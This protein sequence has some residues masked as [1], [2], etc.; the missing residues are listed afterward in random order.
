MPTAWMLGEKMLTAG[1]VPTAGEKTE[2]VR[3][4][5]KMRIAKFMPTVRKR[6]ARNIVEIAGAQDARTVPTV[7]KMTVR[8]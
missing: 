2:W 4:V 3:A 8:V 5:W 1:F 6:T 7:G